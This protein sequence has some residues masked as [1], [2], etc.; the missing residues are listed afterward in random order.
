MTSKRTR[1]SI[2]YRLSPAYVLVALSAWAMLL[3]A[4]PSASAAA[5]RYDVALLNGSIVDGSGAPSYRG[6]LAI[7]GGKI[8]AVG[9]LEADSAR[10]AIDVDGLVVAPGF[11]DAHS[12]AEDGLV[13]PA[14][15][16]NKGFVTQGVTTSVFGVD[17]QYSLDTILAIRRTLDRQGVGTNYM[18]YI[19]HNGVRREVIGMAERAPTSVEM[20][21]MREQVAEA[22]E[23]GM[24]GLSSGLMYLPGRYAET[25][26][27]I[28]LA[29][30][31]RRFGGSYDSHIRDPA[32]NLLDSIVECLEIGASSGV[33]ANI[34]HVKAV[35]RHNFGASEAIV[36]IVDQYVA[37]GA[38]VTADIYPY[39]GAAARALLNILVPP[40]DSPIHA[41][42]VGFQ[43][44]ELSSV[45]AAAFVR[46]LETYWRRVLAEPELRERARAA[47]EDP[48]QGVFSWIDAVGYESFRVVVSDNPDLVGRMLVDLA[49]ERGRHPFEQIA[50]MVL[51]E[52]T[53]V[54]ITLGAIEESDLRHLLVQPWVMIASDGRLTGFQAGTAHPRFRGSFARVLGRYVREWNVLSLEEAV[55]KMTSLPADY[56]RLY[57]RGRIRE[58]NWAD[59]VVFDS[60]SIIDNATWD[61]PSRYSSGVEHVLVNGRFALRDGE[62]TGETHGRFL[63]A[64]GSDDR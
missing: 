45:E 18:F 55:R 41:R 62:M 43:A 20:D 5:P 21:R 32:A 4:P 15:R 9:E 8:V 7:A 34:A 46:E 36:D 58:G 57:D 29:T 56:L 37:R 39:D 30:V 48:G 52:G 17:G 63:A 10:V 2:G 1:G 3:G 27:L 19:G 23:Q 53:R 40:A 11:I 64:G 51:A 44:G 13:N 33:P 26:E 14:L 35:G 24:V 28:E 60:G 49:R 54:K 22:M 16:T 59:I 50:E 38:R 42:Y 47:S 25:A 12:H 61:D 31:V 6:D